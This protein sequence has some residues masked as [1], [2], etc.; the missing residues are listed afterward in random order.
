MMADATM[1]PATLMPISNPCTANSTL[2][3][4]VHPF[5]VETVFPEA[6]SYRMY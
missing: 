3:S 1:E 6:R 5:E 4:V 2:S